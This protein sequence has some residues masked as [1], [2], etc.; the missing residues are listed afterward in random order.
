[1]KK[2]QSKQTYEQFLLRSKFL[3]QQAS[4]D[5]QQRPAEPTDTYYYS[6]VDRSSAMVDPK[7]Q[8]FQPQSNNGNML[9][10]HLPSPTTTSPP[11]TQFPYVKTTNMTNQTRPDLMLRIPAVGPYQSSMVASPSMYSEPHTVNQIQY[12]KNNRYQN[13]SFY[14]DSH[15]GQGEILATPPDTPERYYVNASYIPNANSWNPPPTH[16]NPQRMVKRQID[17]QNQLPVD[18]YDW[19][20]SQYVKTN[21]MMDR[22]QNYDTNAYYS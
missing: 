7:L 12:Q 9:S 13:Q 1:M 2:K 21:P 22:T 14:T 4:Q 3:E 11:T 6:S 20:T 15:T 19:R 10:S 16:V 5:E 17:P 8:S 18:T